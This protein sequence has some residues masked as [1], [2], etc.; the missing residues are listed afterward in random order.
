MIMYYFLDIY[1]VIMNE[2]Y[3]TA[4]II[5]YGLSQYNV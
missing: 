5:V 4:H 2:K 3:L 1:D